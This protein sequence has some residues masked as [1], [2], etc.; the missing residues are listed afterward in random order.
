[1]SS[2][3]FVQTFSPQVYE[4]IVHML[5]NLHLTLP[6]RFALKFIRFAHKFIRFEHKFEQKNPSTY[7]G[8]VHT[9]GGGKKIV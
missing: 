8:R 9:E 3:S 5:C 2:T 4:A 7:D 6:I 1:M